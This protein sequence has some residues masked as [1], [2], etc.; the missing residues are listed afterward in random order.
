MGLYQIKVLL[1]VTETT[2][3]MTDDRIFSSCSSDRGLVSRIH[4]EFKKIK[5]QSNK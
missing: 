1:H 5:L 2:L 3:A 4:K